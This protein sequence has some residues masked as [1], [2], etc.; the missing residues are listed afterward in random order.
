M[1]A[2][3]AS[4]TP[5]YHT[6]LFG[7]LAIS[8]VTLGAVLLWFSFGSSLLPREPMMQGVIA[9]LS[10]TFGYALGVLVWFLVRWVA[11]LLGSTFSKDSAPSWLRW[12]VLGMVAAIF[13]VE[14][15]RWSTWQSEQRLL[16]G[17]DELSAISGVMAVAWT[18][19]F[20][21]VLLFIGRSIRWLVWKLDAFNERHMSPHIARAVSVLIIVGIAGALYWF[22]ASSGLTAFANERFGPGDETTLEGITQ[23]TDPDAS[24]SPESLVEWD[25]LGFQ[26]R[27]FAG[28]GTT[29]NDMTTFDPDAQPGAR[30]P[31]RVYAGLKSAESSEARA[32]LVVDELNRTNAADRS[33]VALVSTTGTGWVDPV[34][35]ATIEYMYN[36]DTA[37]AAMQYSFLPSWISFILDTATATEAG[38]AINTA[39]IE[40]WDALAEN[41]RPR[42]IAFGESL[43]T[44]GSEAAYAQGD[45]DAS[46]AFVQSKVDGVLWVGPTNANEI[47]GQYTQERDPSPVWKPDYN[48]GA[49]VRTFNGPGEFDPGVDPWDEPR[50]LYY[51]HPSDPVGYWNWETLWKPQEWTDKPVGY[52]VPDSVRW[53]PFTTFTQVVVDLINGFSASVGH[54]HNYNNVFTDGWSVVTPP[55]GWTDAD[56][57]RLEKHVSVLDLPGL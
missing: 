26:G 23:P 4:A 43:G 9:A 24:G 15:F 57:L 42:L 32:Q 46:L 21:A 41:D 33:V 56:T 17:L 50:V 53:I 44:L 18:L 35:A 1:M 47:H 13:V 48:G 10:F 20:T 34:A 37:I 55:D 54:G 38:I 29:I 40:W 8:G 7:P 36:G 3:D 30:V 51:H 6:V 31:I 52:D 19:V 5:P 22:I 11:K 14:I 28:S 12:A 39:V 27:T 45:L 16:V 49:I 25:D 2:K